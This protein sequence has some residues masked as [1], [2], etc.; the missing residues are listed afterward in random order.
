MMS[1]F[2]FN[3]L[4]IKRVP[5]RIGFFRQQG[6][7]CDFHRIYKRYSTPSMFPNTGIIPFFNDFALDLERKSLPKKWPSPIQRRAQKL[8]E[9]KTAQ[10]LQ[11]RDFPLADLTHPPQSLPGGLALLWKQVLLLSLTHPRQ[12]IQRDL[13]QSAGLLHPFFLIFRHT[14]ILRPEIWPCPQL[15]PREEN[16]G[17]LQH[18]CEMMWERESENGRAK[19]RIGRRHESVRALIAIPKCA[20]C[21]D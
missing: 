2:M 4:R 19:W 9:K 8:W 21:W 15:G 20:S 5:Y 10:C 3:I 6:V 14:L 1:Q 18:K 16:N 11:R 7:P 13:C 12:I 17:L